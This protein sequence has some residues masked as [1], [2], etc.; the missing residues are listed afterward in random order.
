MWILW[1]VALG[2]GLAMDAFAVSITNGLNDEKMKWPRIV[3]IALFFGVFQGVM[4]LIGYLSGE[5]LSELTWFKHAIPIIGFVILVFLG[6]KSIVEVIKE[7]KKTND[8]TDLEEKEEES[9]KKFTI[10]LLFLQAIATSIDALTTGIGLDNTLSAT[11]SWQVYAGIIIVVIVAFIISFMG[12]HIG[13]K[14]KDKFNDKALI[15]GG[16]ILI[17]IA[18]KILITYIIELL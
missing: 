7:S 5:L 9:P 16:I 3:L 11:S 1:S 12:V 2:V 4:P 13:K 10:G 6:T 14:F 8:V 17:G 15:F 18:L